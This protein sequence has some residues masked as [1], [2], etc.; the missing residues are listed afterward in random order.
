MAKGGIIDGNGDIGGDLYE[1][2]SSAN[3]KA[4]WAL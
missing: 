1:I 3:R 2:A 4:L